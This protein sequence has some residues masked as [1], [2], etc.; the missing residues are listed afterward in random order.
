MT[1]SELQAHIDNANTAATNGTYDEAEMLANEVLTELDTTTDSAA[2][3]LSDVQT[4]RANA[5]LSLGT[6][7]WRRGNYDT[8]LERAQQALAL[9]EEH[10][11]A[12]IKPKCWNLFGNVYWKLSDSPRALEYYSKALA[13][14]EELGQKA[15]AARVTGNIGLVYAHLS[16]YPRALEYY[17]KA[18]AVH[19]ELRQKADATG[20]MG[21]IG[22]VY[23]HLS[24]YPRALEYFGKALAAHEA[25]GQK[26]NAARV[27]G[28]IGNV[29]TELSDHPRALEY[30]G[31]ALA[32]LEELGQ[33]AAAAIVIGNI[34]GVY[35]DLSD[36]PR[37]LEYYGR[38]LAA[39]EELGQKA[40]AANLTGNIGLLYGKKEFAG[41]DPV[42]AEEYLLKAIAMNEELG[43]KKNL[44]EKH[45]AIAGLYKQEER[46]KECQFHFEKYHELEKE[47]QSE[48]AKKHA[49]K[50]D[51]DRKLAIE[52]A[53][54]QATDEILANILPPNITERLIK[55][56]KKIADAHESVSV[57][58]VDIVGFT[59]MS[60]A[61]SAGELIDLLDI[62]FTRFDVIC[63]KH[64]LEKIKT[65]GD[66]YM[67]VCGAPVACANHAERA[68]L[69]AL[70]M[71][72]DFSIDGNFSAPINVGFR[73]GLHTGSVVAG[74]IGE[75]KYSYDMWGDAVNTA[76]RMES[77]G[78]E[79]KIHVSEE[80][81]QA[82]LGAD[83]QEQ[84]HESQTSPKTLHFQERGEMDI[85][86]KGMM[87]TYFLTK[88]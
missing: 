22:I 52:R 29:Y 70:E 26:A 21:N 42:R 6:T 35:V 60:T 1:L 18:L 51:T 33:K 4:L 3:L 74:I 46:W 54:A 83:R 9:A 41:Y 82:F 27:T 8:A 44:Y 11:L 24:D 88:Q 75:N 49:E 86:G 72:E 80:F 40:E 53:R 14:H 34:G 85:K 10:S 87:K 77:Y 63:K 7:A 19:E 36:Y 12:D 58:F 84:P 55:G 47:V 15:D 66:A 30:Y 56:E 67:A 48:E 23:A 25:L 20:L 81:K 76:S 73:I 71:L 79:D 43:I 32:A 57:L 65:I 69:A 64:G 61:L 62:V 59:K 39:H 37:A 2:G 45:K 17:A 38:A 78:E 28:N 13:A 5:L 50:Q 31:K 68:A 16:D